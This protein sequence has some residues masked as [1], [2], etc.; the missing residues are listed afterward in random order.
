MEHRPE[1]FMIKPRVYIM[2]P[3]SDGD[4]LGEADTALNVNNAMMAFF[5]LREKGFTPILPH[6]THFLAPYSPHRIG[7]EEWLEYGI[8]CMLGCHVSWRLPGNSE[9]ADAEEAKATQHHIVVFP[10]L[11]E[12]VRY[13]P[14]LVML[15]WTA[16]DVAAA[17]KQARHELALSAD[18]DD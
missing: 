3:Y 8:E 1:A 12:L 18:S 15:S 5:A 16:A 4:R 6:L 7:H 13:T 17:I 10:C 9:G 2:G 14:R 11:V